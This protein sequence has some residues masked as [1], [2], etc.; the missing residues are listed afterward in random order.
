MQ[1]LPEI[2][3]AIDRKWSELRQVNPRLHDGP[4]LLAQVHE[5]DWSGKS[6]YIWKHNKLVLFIRP[7][8]YKTLATAAHIGRE[9]RALGVQGVVTARD[10]SGE[11]H[12]LLGR[13]GSEVR[14]YQGLWENAPSG[15]VTPPPTTTPFLDQTHFIR[16]LI[17]EGLEETGLNLSDSNI[18]WIAMLNDSQANALDVVLKLKM[19]HTIDPRAV[20]CPANDA[21]NWEYAATI[22]T[23]TSTVATWARQNAHAIS[24]PTRAVIQ[25]LF[26]TPASA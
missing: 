15:T 17:D 13:R 12:L 2:Q 18:S 14:I 4:I 7:D 11:E 25:W 22:W 23:P 20:P 1:R 3:A 19:R 16:A 24:P 8:T 5:C 10:P 6:T 21:H 9:V 26:E